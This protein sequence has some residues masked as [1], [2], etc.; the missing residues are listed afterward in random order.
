MSAV[1]ASFP[2]RLELHL[3]PA[4]A[5]WRTI[6]WRGRTAR[7]EVLACLPA[8]GDAAPWSAAIGAARTLLGAGGRARARRF[9]VAVSD[10]FM[11]YAVI[12]AAAGV[13]RDAERA[14]YARHLFR[15]EYGAAVDRW[16]VALDVDARGTALA[17]LVEPGLGED[18]AALGAA[19]GLRLASLRPHFAW[20]QAA[21]ARRLGRTDLWLA[22]LEPGYCTLAL[23]A[24]GTWCDLAGMRVPEGGPDGAFLAAAMAG[25]A[26][27]VERAGEVRTLHVAGWHGSPA[28]LQPA[29]GWQVQVHRDPY[30]AVAR[31]AEWA[32]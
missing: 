16:Q 22:V 20:T 6:D 9:A 2:N 3:R 23:M 13:T 1:S 26:W 27:G 29:P 19:A 32:A 30:A 14:A 8:E 31:P 25:R 24:G 5:A 15:G 10:S 17:G 7:E 4:L 11:R 12:P 21:L 18:V 28:T